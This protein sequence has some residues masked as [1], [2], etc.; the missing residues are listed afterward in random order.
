MTT[1]ADLD[2]V[3]QGLWSAAVIRDFRITASSANSPRTV[4]LASS[5]HRARTRAR[6]HVKCVNGGDTQPPWR[7]YNRCVRRQG[8]TLAW[9]ATDLANHV[10]CGHLTQL[11]RRVADGELRGVTNFDPLLT[12]LAERGRVHEAAYLDH[13]RAQGLRVEDAAALTSPL[14]LMAAG[15]DVITQARLGDDAWGGRADVLL[16]VATPSAAWAW[17][18]EVIDAKLASETRAG[19]VLQLCVYTELLGELQGLVPAQMYIVRPGDGGSQRGAEAFVREAFRFAEFAAIYRALK[20][21]LET[22]SQA[23]V[24]TYPEPTSHCETCNWR[25]RCDAERRADDHLSL[26]AGLSRGHARELVAQ[27]ITTLTALAAAPVP[28]PHAPSHG[29]AT[30]YDRLA[31]QARLQLAARSMDVPPY[32]LLPCEPT[33]GLGRLPAPDP[34]D[35]FLDLEGDAFIGDGGREYLF[36][37]ATPDGAYHRAWALDDASERAAFEALMDALMAR[38]AAHPG[39][40]IYHFAPYETTAF[41]RLAGRYATCGDALDQLLRGERFIDLH[42]VTR[43]ALRAGV[44]SYSIKHLESL[45]GFAR[46]IELSAAGQSHHALK[47]MLQRGDASAIEPAWQRDVEAYNRDDCFAAAALRDWLEARRADVVNAGQALVRP[48]LLDGLP[49]EAATDERTAPQRTAA[50]LLANVPDDTAARTPEQHATYLLAHMMEWYA[51]EQ[52][53][54]WWE[55]F[56]L[57]DLDDEAR[58]DEPKAIAGLVHMTQI[59]GKRVPISRYRFALQ[60]LMLGVDDTLYVDADQKLGTVAAIDRT[61]RTID[62]KKTG[63]TADLHPTSAIASDIIGPKPKDAALHRLGA[64]VVEHGFPPAHTASLARDLLLRAPPRGLAAPGTALQ[65]SGESIVAC[66]ERLALALVDTVLPMQGPPGSGKTETAARMIVA[67]ARAGRRVG[68]TATSHAVIDNLVRRAADLAR[69]QGAPLRALLKRE[70]DEV[71]PHPDIRTE[72]NSTNAERLG[73]DMDVVGATAWHWARESM[74]GAVDVLIID[75]AGQLSLADALAVCGA[76]RAL[77]LV[78][79]PQQLEQPITGTHPDGVAVSVLEHLLQGAATVAPERGLFLGETHRLHPTLCAFTSE[80]FYAGR[81]AS[82]PHAQRQDICAPRLTGPGLYWLPVTA[83]G[84]THR[85]EA[86]AD[87]VADTLATTLGG[88]STWTRADGTTLPLT[89]TDIVVVAP[90]NAH[91]TLVHDT[92]R[93][94]GLGDVRVGTVDKF[95]GQQATLAIYTM[96]TSRP[97]DAPRGLGFLYDRHRLN[98]A[99]SR[100]RCASLLVCNPA[101]L[102]PTCQ[103]PAHLRLA[104]TLARYVE[105]ATRL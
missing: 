64:H 33:R 38:W 10:A 68:V 103:T 35:V 31:H 57:V 32:E 72:N 79:D 65:R 99:T 96:A 54:A 83:P 75:E 92:L 40:H 26:V 46:A 30:T 21:D 4:Q 74:A 20:Q 100:A 95:Q 67:L 84:H 89:P 50:A 1:Y 63:A 48:P 29:H 27:H 80:Q 3:S 105:L 88:G 55:R 34:G 102:Q 39:M 6:P 49:G 44:E 19:A 36:G 61:A 16:R 78:G 11:S 41:R 56:R 87:A 25:S 13:L 94:R 98:V 5:C 37:W 73:R 90:Y 77:I 85:N 8:K 43:E 101:L 28:W 76:T 42:A 12:I 71:A 45:F 97:E 53:V 17:S 51:R 93:A 2:A 18:Y 82:A 104:S 81:L 15:V 14:E 24:A 86:E 22:Q 23:S 69:A 60:E 91:V 58:L 59:P 9:S 47:L 7:T 62:I 70:A 52:K 66:A